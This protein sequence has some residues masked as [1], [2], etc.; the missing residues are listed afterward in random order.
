MGKDNK[1]LKRKNYKK[2]I[3]Q[4]LEKLN[5]RKNKS[6]LRKQVSS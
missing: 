6:K 2:E 1:L 3:N 5:Q 4:I